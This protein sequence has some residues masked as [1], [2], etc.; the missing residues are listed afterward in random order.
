ME[1]SGA[2]VLWPLEHRECVSVKQLRHTPEDQQRGPSRMTK[3][4]PTE[5][6]TTKQHPP[7]SGMR[8]DPT[9]T[10][11]GATGRAFAPPL[12]SPPKDSQ[13]LTAF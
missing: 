3:P 13:L 6:K 9:R 10:N 11:P 2:P 7:K 8:R 5:G 12:Q 4:V 1:D